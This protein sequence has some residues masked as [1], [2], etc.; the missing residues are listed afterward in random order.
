MNKKELERQLVIEAKELAK[1]E[2]V[3]SAVQDQWLEI[4]K[5]LDGQYTLSK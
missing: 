5:E 3:D 2:F 4:D 1:I